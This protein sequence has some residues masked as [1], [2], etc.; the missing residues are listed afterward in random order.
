M[1]IAAKRPESTIP[2]PEHPVTLTMTPLGHLLLA[3]REDAPPVPEAIASRLSEAFRQGSGHGLLALGACET[4]HVGAVPAALS[5]EHGVGVGLDF[6]R[7]HAV[8][9]GLILDDVVD[10]AHE[11]LERGEALAEE[12]V[13]KSRGKRLRAA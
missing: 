13:V 8:E 4:Q 10:I 7:F 12:F 1:A 5:A 11:A 2:M 6:Q 3:Q 9:L